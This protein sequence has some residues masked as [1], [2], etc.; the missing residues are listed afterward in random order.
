MKY[1]IVLGGVVVNIV[2]W[3][4]N[5]NT[6]QP[7]IGSQAVK[8]DAGSTVGAG[9]LY[10]GD[11][12]TDT[13]PAPPPPTFA[14]LKAGELANFRAQREAFLNR[15]AGIGMAAQVNGQPAVAAN[16]ALVRQGLLDLPSDPAVLAATEIG[17]LKLAMKTK[18]NAVKATASS[19]VLLA[20]S[21]VDA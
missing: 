9:F 8:L 19:A 3:D 6:W 7:D 5:P 20:Y 17:A 13:T 1:A 4:G 10:V 18:Y 15:L 16:C 2:E 21:K 14:S 12:F 11:I